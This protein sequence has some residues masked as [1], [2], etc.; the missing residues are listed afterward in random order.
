MAL[1]LAQY[2]VR[3][4]ALLMDSGAAIWTVASDV[5]AECIRLALHEYSDVTPLAM[6]TYIVA[7]AKG[8]EIALNGIAGLRGVT[9]VWFPFDP[10]VEDWPPPHVAFRVWWDHAQ[11]VLF[12]SPD[13]GEQPQA[14]DKLRIFYTKDHMVEGLDSAA[15]TTIPITHESLVVLGAAGYACFARSVDVSETVGISAVTTPNLGAL[16]SRYLKEFRRRL[17]PLRDARNTAGVSGE[18]TGAGWKMDQWD[19]KN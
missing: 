11:P 17:E 8:R 1:T 16:G 9:D 3:V 10:D 19:G 4:L 14:D 15:V 6:E 2:K 5:S 7:P 13:T 18:A 12:L